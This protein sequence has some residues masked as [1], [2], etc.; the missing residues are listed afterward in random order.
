MKFSGNDSFFGK[1]PLPSG[2]ATVVQGNFALFCK[3]IKSKLANIA[4]RSCKPYSTEK[5]FV[6][7]GV[8]TYYHNA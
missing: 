3:Q 4:P 5:W 2:V 7:K 6:R 1:N 8:K